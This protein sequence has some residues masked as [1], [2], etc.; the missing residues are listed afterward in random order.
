M[1]QTAI[2]AGVESVRD[3]EYFNDKIKC[4]LDIRKES[5][6][7]FRK[8]GFSFPESGANFLFVTHDYIPAKELYEVLRENRI[9]VRYFDQPRINNHLRITIG[10]R[11]QMNMLFEFLDNYINNR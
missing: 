6:E 7:T 4:L 8:L 10:S 11:E 5:E 9:Y 2:L 3:R 1:N